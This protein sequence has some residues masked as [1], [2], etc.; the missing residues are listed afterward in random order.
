MSGWLLYSIEPTDSHII[1]IQQEWIAR[2]AQSLCTL[3]PDFLDHITDGVLALDET[4][5]IASLNRATTKMFGYSEAEML[6]KHIH[7]FIPRLTSDDENFH[8][9]ATQRSRH[10]AKGQR[11]SGESFTI[12]LTIVEH[13]EPDSPWLVIVSD[14]SNSKALEESILDSVEKLLIITEAAQDAII[15]TDGDGSLKF[16]NVATQRI[17]GLEPQQLIDLTLPELFAEG[18]SRNQLLELINSSMK[19]HLHIQPGRK[20]ELAG[21]KGEDDEFIAE[22]SLSPAHTTSGWHMI[23]IVSDVT[24]ERQ[25][26]VHLRQAQKLEAVAQLASGI[27]H[28]INT[29]SQ[30][31]RDNLEFMKENVGDLLLLLS[32]QNRL[33]NKG[34]SQDTRELIVQCKEIEAR[35]DPEFTVRELPKAIDQS[36]EGIDRITE[37]VKAMKVFSHPGPREL[38]PTDINNSIESTVTV[39]RNVWKRHA[40]MDLQL[41]PTLP[42]VPCMAGMFNQVILNLISNATHAIY[43]RF[44]DQTTPQGKISIRT[45]IASTWAVIDV[46]DNGI[47]IDPEIHSRIYEPFFTTKDVG[48]GTGQGLSISHSVIVDQHHG[49]IQFESEP[50]QGTHFTIRLPLVSTEG[51]DI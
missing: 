5:R 42:L 6:G 22:L 12:G 33:I 9:N 30:Y 13:H 25:L 48:Q 23:V 31:V 32:L 49:Q 51:L 39:S 2:M 38:T 11:K 15:M 18:D 36:L 7:T 3:A 43:E 37:I 4:G 1:P 29:P 17:F 26:E 28:E 8:P 20:I 35:L 41:D 16:F 50:G 19:N 34:K 45:A 21:L 47:G 10:E 44:G 24:Q 46:E 27:A 14:I 40:V